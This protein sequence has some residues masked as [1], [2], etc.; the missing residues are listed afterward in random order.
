MH[1]LDF[2]NESRSQIETYGGIDQFLSLFL[3]AFPSAPEDEVAIR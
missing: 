3:I 1:V 2:R